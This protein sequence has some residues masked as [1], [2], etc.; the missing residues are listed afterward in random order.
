MKA[1]LT[2]T[3]GAITLTASIVAHAQPSGGLFGYWDSSTTSE[4]DDHVNA[5]VR[6]V[7]KADESA[8]TSAALQKLSDADAH[9]LKAIIYISPF[10]FDSPVDQNGNMI[11]KSNFNL[12]P[13]AS[14]HF[15][16]L[17]QALISNGYLVPNNPAA[18]TV[19]AFGIVE[20]PEL[21]DLGD[22]S[23]FAHSDLSSAVSVVNSHSD[24]SNFPTFTNVHSN[25]SGVSEG[26]KLMD[27][28]G[29][30][31]YSASTSSYIGHIIQF[32]NH[33]DAGQK[34][35]LFPQ[36]S[37][38]G[39]MSQYGAWHDPDEVFGWFEQDSRVIGI[40]PFL[41]SNND[42]DGVAGIPSLLGAWSNYGEQ[43]K[44]D[45]IIDTSVYCQLEMGS[46]E[47]FECNASASGGSGGFSFEWQDGQT[48]QTA[49]FSLPCP[50]PQSGD[51]EDVSETI[52]VTVT[53][54]SGRYRVDSDVIQ[55]P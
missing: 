48:G 53:D 26:V 7:R 4:H 43:I 24:T 47:D 8:A 33:L 5:A 15:N 23:G 42:T 34:V 22:Q 20:E 1:L 44:Y 45:S 28:V 9:G 55:C 17:V 36:A 16:N 35:L 27:W 25:W 11:Y 14:S 49:G 29:M 6:V 32:T 21:H 52:Q 13:N 12:D 37:Y 39:F 18:S 46:W 2:V 19:I 51:G 10:L 41:W 40:V 3:L 31:D 30:H 54:T 50:H 38:G